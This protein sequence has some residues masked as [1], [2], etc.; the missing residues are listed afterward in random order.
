MPIR[1]MSRVLPAAFAA[2]L[3][4]LCAMVQ[5]GGRHLGLVLDTS[6][7]MGRADTDRPRYAVQIAKILADLLGPEDAMTVAWI[8]KD[9][10]CGDG[11]RPD[12]VLALDPSRRAQLEAQLD[13]R[14]QYGG[15][16]NFVA[17]L[18]TVAQAFER[19]P[20][21]E[22]LLI[23]ITD[24]TSF[25]CQ[26]DTSTALRGMREA[27][28]TLAAVTLGGSS[29]GVS[30]NRLFALTRAAGS[31]AELVDA[32]GEIYQR[33]LGA[34]K[35]SAGRVQGG[36][37][38]V[39][40]GPYVREAFLLVAAEGPIGPLRPEP[41]NPA[42]TQIDPDYRGGGSTLGLDGQVRGYRIARLERP[43]GGRWRFRA[44]ELTGGA[45][46]LLLQ[47]FSL[48][49]RFDPPASVAQGAPTVFSLELVDEDAGGRRVD[50]ATVPGLSLI[51]EGDGLRVALNDEGRDGD[52]KAGDGLLSA[53]VRFPRSG[54]TDL[55]LHFATDRIERRRA[56]ALDVLEAQWVMRTEAPDRA[57]VS[58]PV[59]LRATLEPFGPVE[60]LRPPQRIAVRT[61]EGRQVA[62]SER[63]GAGSGGRRLYAGTWT[64]GR[65]GETR[66]TFEAVA[67]RPIAPQEAV[68]RVVGD[69]AF[70]DARD[71]DLG[72]GGSG[73]RLE[74]TLDLSFVQI[75]GEHALT[76]ATDYRR[77]GTALE[78]DLGTGWQPLDRGPVPLTLLAQ[79]QRHFPLRL[80]IG[81]CPEGSAG[82]QPFAISVAAV[83]PDG[84]PIARR[85]GL[86]L[87]VAEDPWYVCWWPVIAAGIGLAVLGVLIHGY[88]SP[89]AFPRNLAV[90]VSPEEDLS[91]GF[92]YLIR[93]QKGTGRGFYRDARAYLTADYRVTGRPANAVARLRADR[94]GVRLSPAGGQ[95][96]LVLAEE[97]R[98]RP[99]EA[100]DTAARFGTLYKTES[101]G[102]YFQ[103]RTM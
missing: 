41:G 91:E 86:T 50:P 66:L 37:V 12:A 54:R 73:D 43:G 42:A 8:P 23:L 25:T 27:G 96:L 69:I 18:K 28:A 63:A 80:R 88:R 61:P 30:A 93:T 74:G 92:P 15:P 46:W 29:G 33:F 70:G 44:P 31:A 75:V 97:G 51:L 77:A 6:S 1:G 85:I 19:T 9:T 24:A 103:L 56:L 47:E 22:R 55:S 26:G 16:T 32:V 7:S 95:N 62:L 81:A 94:G 83:T 72:R 49:L 64:P 100:G 20:D 79:G 76:L 101:G 71:L 40:V 98:W 38:E 90:Q 58:E 68:V 48:A 14:I 13:A 39:D 5:A 60:L 21:K 3:L 99:L 84:E 34:K 53:A 35:P 10:G 87:A 17:P 11:P 102:L 59:E 2:I 89:A 57:K 65:V 4:V 78:A 45:G 67:E 36:I 52:A 82:S